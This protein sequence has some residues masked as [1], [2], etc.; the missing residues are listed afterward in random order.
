MALFKIT[1]DDQE[2]FTL[3]THPFQT[4]SSG[5]FGA[6]VT[7][8]VKV[9]PRS[10]TLE[11]ESETPSAFVDVAFNAD[12]ID[13]LLDQARANARTGSSYYNVAGSNIESSM[14]AYL[15]AVNSSSVSRRKQQEVNVIRFEPSVR[16]TKD[17][18][19]KNL[20]R[21][22]YMPYYRQLYP[23]MQYGYT[24]Y[25]CLNF[26]TASS[27]SD[28]SVILYPNSS[29]LDA[30]FASSGSYVLEGPFTFDF[31]INPKYTT[32]DP[33]NTGTGG[34]FRAGTIFHLSSSYAVSLVSGSSLDANGR[35]SAY[36]LM[37]QLTHSADI[38]PSVVATSPT[39]NTGS[40]GRWR[41][42]AGDDLIFLSDDNSLKR[43]HWHHV[44]I[45]WGTNSINQGS[46]SFMI[47]RIERGTFVVTES[48]VR[49]THDNNPAVLCIGNFYEGVNNGISAQATF[50]AA[51]PNVVGNAA[52]QGPAVRDGL[53]TMVEVDVD[54]TPAWAYGPST[55]HF[56]H[57]LNAEVHDLKI[58]KSYRT[59]D[60]ISATSTD[61]VKTLDDL[62][63]YVP[64]F[65][66]KESPTRQYNSVTFGGGVMQTPFF[67][68]SSSTDDPFNVAMSFG[69]NGHDI[70]LENWGRDFAT[71][72]YPRWLALTCSEVT[73][74][75]P[76]L[77]CNELL[78]DNPRSYS[79][80]AGYSM[81]GARKRQLTALPC[82]NGIFRPN[83]ELLK[84]GTFHIVPP[85]GS[86]MDRFTDDFGALDLSFIR[87][88]DLVPTSSLR[89]GLIPQSGS[90]MDTI[91][92]ATPENPGVDPGEVLT[93]FQ[94]THDNSS[95]EVVFFDV[96]NLFYG[97]QIMSG[98]V[99]LT[100]SNLSMSS[101]KISM[102]LRDNGRGNIYRAD[103]LTTHATW[104]SVGNVMYEEGL[105]IV[106]SPNIPFFGKEQFSL[107]LRGTQNIH[108]LRFN[109]NAAK[110]LINSSS[111][112][113][114]KL[115]SASANANDTDPKFVYIDSINFH[116]ENLNV[117]MK[118]SF[119]Q[120]IVKRD[121]DKILFKPK[122]DF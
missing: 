88:R 105:I 100:D 116:D 120:P 67:T 112:P 114:Y 3:E 44:A 14:T 20:I 53:I 31:Y 17:T 69:V 38:P 122:I 55:F 32:D 106:K 121:G 82:D 73:W 113:S 75:T 117:I 16:F 19:R 86:V 15:E 62:L 65:F 30:G 102:T 71:G 81:G 90:I 78:F 83:F 118:T 23:S 94:R 98:T 68:V 61:G 49:L 21:D 2:Y 87:L 96:S 91:L 12:T 104:N 80:P 8:S 109:V 54:S 79:G 52:P 64:P 66:T 28:S 101:G 76:A 29:S 46:G 63:F 97:Q 34:I 13:G 77:T 59:D 93:I 103:A 95:N 110:G 85:S 26:F 9:F 111:N 84:S 115:L 27:V 41:T 48:S 56:K 6:G 11:K 57:A 107:S 74:T 39:S 89:P 4:F 22:V 45:R 1:E 108:T 7:G 119:A 70:N 72:I 33:V 47:D 60:Q 40:K 42:G 92:G 51:D 35:P 58:F 18:M 37:L 5:T 50:F 36:R 43:N 24:N 99:R 10:S 25:H